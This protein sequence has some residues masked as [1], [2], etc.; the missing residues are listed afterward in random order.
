MGSLIYDSTVIEF[1]D[2]LLLHL[3]IVIVNKL[4]RRESF[5]MSWRDAPEIGDGRS[6]IWLD[7]SIPLYFKFSGSRTPSINRDWLETLAE[8]AASATGLVVTGED[9]RSEVSGR[10][11]GSPPAVQHM[12]DGALRG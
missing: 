3:Q 5:A 4:R 8:S 11:V 2:R 12:M 1:D 7:P 10:G 6:T 9:G